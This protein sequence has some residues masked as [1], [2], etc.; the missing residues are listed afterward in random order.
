MNKKKILK[1][2]FSLLILMIVT[3]CRVHWDRDDINV[4]YKDYWN[5]SLGEDYNV[6]YKVKDDNGSNGS[7]GFLTNKWFEFTFSFKDVNNNSRSIIINN[8]NT[9]DFNNNLLIA[10]EQFL[11]DDINSIFKNHKF[12]DVDG[13]KTDYR[14]TY[15]NAE[16]MDENI[17]LYDSTI[18]LNF[19]ELNLN[20]LN[21]NNIIIELRTDVDL[22]GGI[23]DYPNLKQKLIDDVSF[24]FDIYEYKNIKF[25]FIVQPS[26][27]YYC[28]HYYL[29][30][31]GSNYNWDIKYN[32]EGK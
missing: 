15:I 32:G 6:S 25:N 29:T 21:K 27:D 11:K 13:I 23:D 5:Y 8:S 1:I 3:G 31:D 10:V 17:N 2:F 20:N 30:Y 7:G 14:F 12:Q 9:K 18:G 28:S 22:N 16:R 19:R 26:N 24:I 4:I